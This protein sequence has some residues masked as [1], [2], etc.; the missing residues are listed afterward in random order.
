[1]ARGRATSHPPA[2]KWR[3]PRVWPLA[4]IASV[5][6]SSGWGLGLGLYVILGWFELD[7]R[8]PHG[9]VGGDRVRELEGD[10]FG[11]HTLS[12][13]SRA[14]TTTKLLLPVRPKTF[15]CAGLN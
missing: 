7:G 3:R 5:F 2:G 8:I 4:S 15:F 13:V 11:E 12:S 1:M 10:L 14:L 9:L 6:G